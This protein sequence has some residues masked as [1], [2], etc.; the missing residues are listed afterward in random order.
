MPRNQL[1]NPPHT[2]KKFEKHQPKQN[3]QDS[4][5]RITQGGVTKDNAATSKNN[6][7]K[8]L[9]STLLSNSSVSTLTSA[10]NPTLSTS[11]QALLSIDSNPVSIP[12][13][14]ITEK[15]I[16]D[17]KILHGKTSDLTFNLS[18]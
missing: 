18:F 6:N 14:A 5:L 16:Y 4:D 15:V 17:Q 3:F 7:A 12:T 13:S 11:N 10:S 8:I 9:T 1:L 2:S